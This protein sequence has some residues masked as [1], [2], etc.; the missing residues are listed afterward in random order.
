MKTVLT[1]PLKHLCSTENQLLK[2]FLFG[3]AFEYASR[4]SLQSH[5][6][7]STS[8]SPVSST[9]SLVYRHSIRLLLFAP[10]AEHRLLSPR[11][12]YKVHDLFRSTRTLSQSISHVQHCKHDTPYIKLI[13]RRPLFASYVMIRIFVGLSVLVLRALYMAAIFASLHRYILCLT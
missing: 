7:L 5:P 6:K 4:L 1:A 12:P 3:I 13:L 8:S 10:R 11:L 2:S 9:T